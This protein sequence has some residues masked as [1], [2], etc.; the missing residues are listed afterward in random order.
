MGEDVPPEGSGGA[1]AIDARE[2]IFRVVRQSPGAHVRE[3]ERL[4]G[5]AYGAVEYHLRRLEKAG[6][7][8]VVEDGN[9]KTYFVADFPKEQR[10]L[11]AVVRRDPIRRILVGLLVRG[12]LSHQEL[13]RQAGMSPSTLT[14]HM[15]KLQSMGVVTQQQEGR[16]SSVGLTDPDAVE[17]AL[18]MQNPT[19]ADPALDAYIATW[20]EW[21]RP[22][23]RDPEAGAE[24]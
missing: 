23:K 18:V 21:R 19:L 13:A 16:R 4:S 10:A 7:I 9:L 22:G 20:K 12:R 6:A 17:R 11:A 5:F 14:H 24:R 15:K 8:R 3:I 1:E 2:R